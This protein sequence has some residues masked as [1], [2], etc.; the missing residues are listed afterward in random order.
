MPKNITIYTTSTCSYCPMVKRY[1]TSKGLPYDEV[2]LEEHPEL[3]AQVFEKSGALT[4][5]VTIITKQDDSEDVVIGYNIS[6]L[7]PAIA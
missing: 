2:N 7:A 1:L 6:R 4:V 5:P 3:Q